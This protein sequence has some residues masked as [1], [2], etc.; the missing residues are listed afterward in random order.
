M[1]SV[2]FASQPPASPTPISA[3][4]NVLK[5]WD[6][7]TQ[8]TPD[9]Q[10]LW[11]QT[12]SHLTGQGSGL[13][14][15][16][17]ASWIKPLSP[18]QID[19]DTFLLLAKNEHVYATVVNRYLGK[20]QSAFT[21]ATGFNH[22]I[23]IIQESDILDGSL[24]KPSVTNKSLHPRYHFDNFVKGKCNE[25]AYAASV[26]VAEEPSSKY[27]PL[28]LHGDVGLGK[29]HLMHSIGNYIISS[30]PTASIL[31]TTSENLV[32]DFVNSIRTG[33]NQ[34]F[35]DKY[36]SVDVLLVDDIQFLSDKEGTQE[37]FFHT[38]NELHSANKQIVLTS[39][40][41]PYELK[42]LEDRLRS[43]FGS[44]LTVDITLPDLETRLAILQ[45][46]VESEKLDISPDVIYF[47]AKSISTNIRELEGALNTVA[48]R[49]KLLGN[50]I[51]ME[52]TES[53]LR[54]MI[55]QNDKREID[56]D[57]IQEIV[58]NYLGVDPSEL[59]G[60]KR[61]ENITYARHIAMYL[62][63]YLVSTSLKNIGRAFGGRDHSTIIHAV[64]KI[65]SELDTNQKL[66]Q[67]IAELKRKLKT[68]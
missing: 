29:T 50:A 66:S 33:R 8:A 13:N 19:G 4:R 54:D 44:G 17:Y 3:E 62:S 59:R 60:K 47:M 11:D 67:E 63:R 6:L 35:R 22:N 25:F 20:V 45:K 48:A 38:F 57:Y 68:E 21:T 39:D 27:N 40:K 64:N 12:T 52:F 2:I 18:Y 37:E 28:F 58:G 36:R 31:Y 55:S 65:E 10:A 32:N 14:P 5:I 49:A 41:N 42:S 24:S 56:V 9:I 16:A 51:T 7:P 1:S 43:R 46:K 23:K 34:E 30:A 53:T 26:A 15:A 61:I